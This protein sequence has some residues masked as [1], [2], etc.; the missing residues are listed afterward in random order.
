MTGVRYRE[1][2]GL[3]GRCDY[4]REWWPLEDDFWRLGRSFRKCRACTNDEQRVYDQQRRAHIYRSPE[5]M[6]RKRAQ[7]NA[8]KAAERRDPVKGDRM[9]ERQREAQRRFYERHRETV[10]ARRR[11]G[12]EARV[13]HPPTPGIGRPRLEVAA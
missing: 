2:T 6:A 1:D 10:L 12:Y 11:A 9:R 7:D 5:A 4:C 3:E 8:R 13:G